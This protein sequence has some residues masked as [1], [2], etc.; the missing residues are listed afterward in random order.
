ML[1][2]KKVGID[3]MCLILHKLTQDLIV[4]FEI[5]EMQFDS[6]GTLRG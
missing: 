5:Y 2:F 1:V 6:Y 4:D 3:F